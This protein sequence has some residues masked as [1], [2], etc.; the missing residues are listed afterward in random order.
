MEAGRKARNDERQ[1]DQTNRFLYIIGPM[2]EGESNGRRNLHPIEE[3]IDL[4]G[5]VSKDVE[6]DP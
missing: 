1:C 3:V 2:A 6:G 5:S 4:R